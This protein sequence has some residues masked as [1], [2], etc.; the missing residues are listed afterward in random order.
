M[1]ILLYQVLAADQR[2][3]PHCPKPWCPYLY[4]G[5]QFRLV[6]S[7]NR[8]QLFA[9]P[10]TAACQASLSITD[11][12]S[13]L[14]LMSIEWVMTS[15]HPI[16]FSHLQSFPASRSFQM[17]QLFTSS[18]QSVGVSAS[19]SVLPMNIQDW[20]PLQLTGCISL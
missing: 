2:Q 11:P 8:V 9:T 17:S 18:S 16:P 5:N 13:L 6:K 7:L 19:T 12:W 4:N 10:W 3:V 20:F 1:Q 15:N 14:K